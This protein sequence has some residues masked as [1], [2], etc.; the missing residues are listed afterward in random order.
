[1]YAIICA[2]LVPLLTIFI[3]NFVVKNVSFGVIFIFM[4][5]F[6][7][8]FFFITTIIKHGFGKYSLIANFFYTFFSV[9]ISIIAALNPNITRKSMFTT[10]LIPNMLL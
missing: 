2:F 9:V 7:I 5:F 8:E 1:M 10:S 4:I 6:V 3:E